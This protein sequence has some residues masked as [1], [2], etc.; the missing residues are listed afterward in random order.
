MYS[1]AYLCTFMCA[2]SFRQIPE[3]LLSAF[4]FG[5]PNYERKRGRDSFYLMPSV[6]VWIHS[7]DLH[8]VKFQNIFTFKEHHY[9]VQKIGNED[10]L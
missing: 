5:V 1:H 4:F 8:F 9:I 2:L 10:K 3:K 6:S 7:R